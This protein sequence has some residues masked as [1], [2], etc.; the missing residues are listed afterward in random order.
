MCYS[1]VLF[2]E[3]CYVG[4]T[5]KLDLSYKNLTSLPA[6]I[7]NLI[8][9]KELHLDNNK[10]TS[11]PAEI[12]KLINLQT[13]YLKNIQLSSLPA[14]IGNLINLK[15]LYLNENQ[16]TSLPAEIGNL[17]NLQELYLD[18]NQ[19]TSLPVEILKIKNSIYANETSYEINNLDNENEILIFS[20]LIYDIT[21]L[22]INTK[23]IWLREGIKVNIKVPFGCN[24]HYF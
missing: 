17:I 8:N 18:N 14:E 21:N 1:V 2:N 6:K 4:T 10:L 15:Y 7:G 13:L 11:L 20:D 22:P 16:L 3:T 9:L 24:L 19:L 12:G 5:T 23:E